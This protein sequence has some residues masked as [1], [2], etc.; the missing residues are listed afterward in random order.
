M[1][2]WLCNQLSRAYQTKNLRQ[3]RLLNE[4]WFFYCTRY[5]EELET[6]LS[7]QGSM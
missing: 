7:E 1:P 6:N 4:C 2:Q 3:V 5:R